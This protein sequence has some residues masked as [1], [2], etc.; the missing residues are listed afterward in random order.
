MQI[1]M[2][3][4]M[5][6]LKISGV[7]YKKKNYVKNKAHKERKCHAPTRKGRHVATAACPLMGP[8]F[9]KTQPRTRKAY[10]ILACLKNG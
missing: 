9:P 5:Q 10:D 7:S 6:L 4:I 8:S 3:I 2:E 1:I